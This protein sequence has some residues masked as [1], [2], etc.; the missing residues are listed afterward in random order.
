[1]DAGTIHEVRY[2]LIVADMVAV[3]RVFALRRMKLIP[4]V[5]L[6]AVF[7]LYVDDLTSP[8]P[9]NGL[10]EPLLAV[11]VPVLI[12]LLVYFFVGIPWAYRNQMRKAPYLGL[13]QTLRWSDGSMTLTSDA[14]SRIPQPGDFREVI[15][16]RA[17]LGLFEHRN[18][19][20]AIPKRAFTSDE[21]LASFRAAARTY[22]GRVR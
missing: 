18:L 19:L 15:E 1:M 4:L 8:N 17:A 10:L 13:P 6:V 3:A 22:V 14:G 7:I 12:V 16:T 2:Q 11:E 21:Q 9:E 20:I 5:A